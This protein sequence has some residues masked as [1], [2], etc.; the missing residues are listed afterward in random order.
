MKEIFL[1]VSLALMPLLSGCG[2][3]SVIYSNGIGVDVGVDPEH[4]MASFTLRY[5][6]TLTAVT[7]DNVEIEL[8]G[9]ADVD[10]IPSGEKK[11]D[12]KV[13]TDDTLRIKIGRQING[14]AVNL[15]E[16]GADA[17]KV[18]EALSDK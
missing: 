11:S 2:H 6:K 16:A 4:F 9:K 12:G 10:G 1:I 7:R 5:G 3:N 8:A 13:G 14:Y 17:Q 15:V 18:V